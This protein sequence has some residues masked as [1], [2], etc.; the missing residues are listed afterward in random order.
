MNT[1]DPYAR[2]TF[3]NYSQ[4]TQTIE[5][6][7]CPTWDETLI[8]DDIEIFSNHEEINA[9]PP[10]ITIEIFDSDDFVIRK[11]F[12]LIFYTLVFCII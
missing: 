4:E 11:M 12:Y 7:L 3:A 8:Y 10:I 2:V 5:K 1:A 6:T 9:N